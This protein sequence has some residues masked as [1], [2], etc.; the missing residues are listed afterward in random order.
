MYYIIRKPLNSRLSKYAFVDK[1][2]TGINA[3]VAIYIG[4]NQDDSTII[5]KSSLQRGLF[6][7]SYFKL[8]EDKE[9]TDTG[10]ELEE[11]FMTM[12]AK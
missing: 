3:I 2:P 4:Y 5:N 11:F 1:L 9:I 10:G 7:S 12:I 8:Y 6:R